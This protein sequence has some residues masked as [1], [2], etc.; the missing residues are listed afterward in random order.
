MKNKLSELL[1]YQKVLK[2]IK[3]NFL[4]DLDKCASFLSIFSQSVLSIF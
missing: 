3:R 4:Y 1:P 2:S